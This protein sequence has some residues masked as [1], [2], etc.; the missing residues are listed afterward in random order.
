MKTMLIL[1]ASAM[2]LVSAGANAARAEDEVEHR[3]ITE[4]THSADE[5]VVI[6]KHTTVIEKKEGTDVDIDVGS[7]G[8]LSTTVDVAGEVL[9]LPF[10]VVGAVFDLAF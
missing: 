6:E 5:P 8:I 10:K 3:V 4:R 1:M 2:I 9:A 7:G